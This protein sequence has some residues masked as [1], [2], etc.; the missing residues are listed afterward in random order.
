MNVFY[1]HP[2]PILKNK[3]PNQRAFTTIIYKKLISGR[4]SF[5]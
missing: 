4:F 5:V 3:S 2:K 1:I